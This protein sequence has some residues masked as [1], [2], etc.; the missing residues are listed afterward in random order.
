MSIFIKHPNGSTQRCEIRQMDERQL[1]TFLSL[2]SAASPDAITAERFL[3]APAQAFRDMLLGGEMLGLF[4]SQQLV[5]AAGW[6]LPAAMRQRELLFCHS[7]A[8]EAVMTGCFAHPAYAAQQPQLHL[9]R[10]CCMR[11]L[12]QAGHRS[13]TAYTSLRD[14]AKTAMLLREGFLLCGF[15]E[16]RFCLPR[17]VFRKDAAAAAQADI[18]FCV[19]FADTYAVT[20]ALTDG[21]AGHALAQRQGETVLWMSPRQG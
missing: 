11:A 1:E 6:Y 12:Q 21:A 7:P 20:R 18:S 19:P 15:D 2:Y 8:N 16:A 4:S 5:A 10:A 14:E 13:L 9:I 3:H 17:Y